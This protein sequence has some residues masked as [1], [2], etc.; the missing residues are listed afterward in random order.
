MHKH[1]TARGVMTK[2]KSSGVNK[3]ALDCWYPHMEKT[4]SNP[5]SSSSSWTGKLSSWATHQGDRGHWT[6]I[7]ARQADG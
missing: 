5:S 6:N 7:V 4:T 3:R 1:E 2:R